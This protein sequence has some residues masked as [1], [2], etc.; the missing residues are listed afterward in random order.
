MAQTQ[1]PTPFVPSTWAPT[2]TTSTLETAPSHGMVGTQQWPKDTKETSN[3]N[4]T[5]PLSAWTGKGSEA[6]PAPSTTRSTFAQDV[7]Q[8]LMELTGVYEHRKHQVLTPYCP[9]EWEVVLQE[10]GLIQKYP[11]IVTGLCVG[12]NIGFPII[13]ATQA[14]PNKD[15][16][17][18]FVEEFE[19]IIHSKI[20]KGR[21]IGPISGQDRNAYQP[22]PVFPLFNYSKARM[23]SQIL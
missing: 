21:Y 8:L 15:S 12:F 9:D 16:V 10:A 19:K 2:C 18:K 5:M 13:T 4:G 7:G 11:H 22:L 17:V 20:Q 23:S 1:K 3:Y 14:P 6:I